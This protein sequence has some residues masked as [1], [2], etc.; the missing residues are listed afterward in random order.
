MDGDW[1]VS[2]SRLKGEEKEY[3]K[4]CKRERK[5]FFLMCF[6]FTSESS[7]LFSICENLNSHKS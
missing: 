3:E 2:P 5:N 6:I 7:V 4:E 1:Y